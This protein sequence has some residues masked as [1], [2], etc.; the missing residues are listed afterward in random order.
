MPKQKYIFTPYSTRQIIISYI[1]HK[2]RPRGASHLSHFAA[3]RAATTLPKEFTELP[4][5]YTPRAQTVLK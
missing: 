5:Q 1:L 3:P 2:L 4:A